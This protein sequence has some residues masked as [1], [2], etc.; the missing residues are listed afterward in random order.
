NLLFAALDVLKLLATETVTLESV[1]VDV[2]AHVRALES[3]QQPPE[4][5]V[6]PARAIRPS[7]LRAPAG[8]THHVLVQF[9]AGP[10]VA[11]RAL[12]AL[13]A[14]GEIGEVLLSNPSQAEIEA[15]H[16]NERLEAWIRVDTTEGALRAALEAIQDLQILSLI[17]AA[18]AM[19]E[20]EL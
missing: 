12:Q 13:L 19:A 1:D 14:M 6:A 20:G 10:W 5:A 16:V 17:D 7:R 11:V 18:E 2:V 15:E 9:D 8:S 4:I 3:W